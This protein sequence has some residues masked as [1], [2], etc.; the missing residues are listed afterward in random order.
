MCLVSGDKENLSSMPKGMNIISVLLDSE[1]KQRVDGFWS[2]DM[3]NSA[4]RLATAVQCVALTHFTLAEHINASA[5]PH[6]VIGKT[7]H[8]ANWDQY[9][10]G[11]QRQRAI[12]SCTVCKHTFTLA[13]YSEAPPQ[14][15]EMM[16]GHTPR[17]T[18]EWFWQRTRAWSFFN[19]LNG[20]PDMW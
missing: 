4:Q 12:H 19:Q 11:K 8:P 20:R 18:R 1:W 2:A 15:T 3:Y 7:L 5:V 14:I 6:G 9:S 16:D 17:H 10:H 13:E